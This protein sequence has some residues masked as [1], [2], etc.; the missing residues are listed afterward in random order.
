TDLVR[1]LENSTEVGEVLSAWTVPPSSAP[2]FVSKDGRT[3]LIVAAIAGG[4]TDAQ[5]NAKR[6]YD[7]LVHDRDGIQVRA[8]GEATVYWQENE[9]TQKE[10]LFMEAGALALG[11][12]VRA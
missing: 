4:E 1:R 3:G 11:F 8:G 2:S 9:Q 12:V 10:L 7:E 6:L 5:V